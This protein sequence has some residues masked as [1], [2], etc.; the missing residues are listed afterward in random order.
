MTCIVELA[1]DLEAPVELGQIV[2]KV[3]LLRDGEEVA[4]YPVYAKTAVERLGFGEC[5]KRLFKALCG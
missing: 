3:R 1:E 2:G 5:I 4:T